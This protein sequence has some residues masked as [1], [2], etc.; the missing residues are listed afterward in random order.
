M[1]A[2]GRLMGGV[3]STMPPA[4]IRRAARPYLA[5]TTVED[6]LRE[7]RALATEGA[8]STIAVLGEAA[9]TPAYADAQMQEM[10]AVL[11]AAAGTGLD[12][13][14]GVK[15]TAIGLCF[16]RDLAIRHLRSL[17]RAARQKG[18]V[19]E[20]DM[21]QAE[22]VDR[23]L[24]AVSTVRAASPNVFAV[25]QAE[26]LR[27]SADVGTLI[28]DRTPTRIVKGT[29]KE[30]PQHAYQLAE[31]I[32]ENFVALVERYLAAGVPVG[33]ATHDEYLV[34]RAVEV[35]DRLGVERDAYEIQ[36]IMGIQLGLRAALL[37]AGRRLRVTVNFGADAHKWSIRRL[38]ENP[39]I[40]R[41]VV[42]GMRERRSS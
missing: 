31:V 39:E 19:L 1:S 30:G 38:K 5:G 18:I 37:A 13:R 32:R 21:E 24:D 20:V 23:T 35:A 42:A 14:L 27:T 15:L 26:L 33:V 36:M 2:T 6:A 40:A 4:L 12:V 17:A 29:Y 3:L 25:V 16:D 28:A 8:A 9:T 10:C 11:D 22:Y 34:Y 41:Y 7:V